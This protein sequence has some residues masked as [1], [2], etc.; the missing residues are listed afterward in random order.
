V[1]N[2]RGRPGINSSGSDNLL[3]GVWALVSCKYSL[4]GVQH[5][6]ERDCG[7]PRDASAGGAISIR[8]PS[9]FANRQLDCH[10]ERQEL[11]EAI[12]K[13]AGSRFSLLSGISS[14]VRPSSSLPARD[15]RIPPHCLKKNGIRNCRHCL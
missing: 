13:R 15:L 9:P 8:H 4:F 7:V 1:K 2:W 14:Y 10:A 6:S 12:R 11:H 3:A 5:N